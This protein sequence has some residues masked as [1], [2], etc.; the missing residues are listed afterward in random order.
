MKW[1]SFY[2]Q[3]FTMLTLCVACFGLILC[4]VNTRLAVAVDFINQDQ[5]D[6]IISDRDIVLYFTSA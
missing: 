6:G 5:R 4:I 1:S 3:P 2:A